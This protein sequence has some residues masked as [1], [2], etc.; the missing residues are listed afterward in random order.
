MSVPRKPAPRCVVQGCT[1]VASHG[2]HMRVRCT[3]HQLVGDRNICGRQCSSPGCST[4]P[5]F[6][7]PG[8]RRLRCGEHR[9][10]D[11]QNLVSRRCVVQGCLVHP[12]FGLPGSRPLFCAQHKSDQHIGLLNR[13]CW[14]GKFAKYGANCAVHRPAN[15]VP[16]KLALRRIVVVL[17]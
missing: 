15:Y 2:P 10:E 9:H 4:C 11:D 14:C 16:A 7:P 3:D 5:S 12:S 8:G 13:T 6:G 1:T 17:Q